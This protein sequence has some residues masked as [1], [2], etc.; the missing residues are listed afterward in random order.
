MSPPDNDLKPLFC[1]GR[2]YEQ[3][4]FEVHSTHSAWHQER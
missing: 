1:N 3:V 4:F 2:Y